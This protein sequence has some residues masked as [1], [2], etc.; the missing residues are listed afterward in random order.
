MGCVQTAGSSVVKTLV[1]LTR[2]DTAKPGDE[3]RVSIVSVDQN[4]S[5]FPL[6][7]AIIKF[8]WQDHDPDYV[9]SPNNGIQMF[10]FW[11]LI[12][13]SLYFFSYRL[14]IDLI[15]D[16]SELKEKRLLRPWQSLLKLTLVSASWEYDHGTHLP[17]VCPLILI[18]LAFS[19]WV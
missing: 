11:F 13:Y 6:K 10:I 15:W 3:G 7:A 5:I 19:G 4:A 9:L 1:Q 12:F 18:S 16:A 17:A 8:A 14:T 2:R